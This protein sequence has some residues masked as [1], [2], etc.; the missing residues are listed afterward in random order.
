[1]NSAIEKQ[2]DKLAAVNAETEAMLARQLQQIEAYAAAYESV[3]AALMRLHAG[4]PAPRPGV[5][6][7]IAGLTTTVA[8]DHRFGRFKG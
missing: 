4:P 5:K 8:E 1:M 7:A 3:I 2:F 6:P